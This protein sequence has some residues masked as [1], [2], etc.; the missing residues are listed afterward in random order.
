MRLQ[1]KGK[2]LEISDS[3]RA[4]A[5]QKL[6]KLDKQLGD[7]VQVELELT[8]EKNPSIRENQVAEATVFTKGHSL[9]VREATNDMRASIDGLTDK[10]M[11]E[12]KEYSEKRRREPRR[13]ADH[14]G[15]APLDER[16]QE[17]VEGR[18]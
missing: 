7:M 9:R 11:R 16:R 5:E 15:V 6:R 18:D 17:G 1:V 14:N 8:V 4:Y 2:N 10:L 13:R 12:V 3:I